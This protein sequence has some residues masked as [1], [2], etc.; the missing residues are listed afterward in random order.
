MNP[1]TPKMAET[2]L[3]EQLSKVMAYVKTFEQSN[4]PPVYKPIIL[5][6]MEEY[7]ALSY[8]GGVW[9]NV[10]KELPDCGHYIV[11][12][13]NPSDSIRKMYVLTAWRGRDGWYWDN[14][15]KEKAEDSTLKITHWM[16]LPKPPKT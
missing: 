4:I 9:V 6:A 11:V 12:Y 10:E 8:K 2:I 1:H 5:T 14:A 3:N 16:P 15:E 13:F 7:A